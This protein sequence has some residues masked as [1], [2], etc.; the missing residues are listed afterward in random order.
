MLRLRLALRLHYPLAGTKA[1]KIKEI[2]LLNFGE[3]ETDEEFHEATNNSPSGYFL[4]PERISFIKLTDK[5][6]AVKGLKFGIE[7]LVN[8]FSDEMDDVEFIC[9]ITHPTLI[10]PETGTISNQTIDK[11]INY[12][13]QNNFDY[14]CFEYDWEMVI[15][16][17]TFEILEEQ[18]LLLKKEFE[19]K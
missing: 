16:T 2:Q 11:K 12:L 15:G 19:I 1:M 9:K 10:N 18:K 4:R 7:Y 17:W 6:K 14:Y 3:L 8:G 13:N 5:L